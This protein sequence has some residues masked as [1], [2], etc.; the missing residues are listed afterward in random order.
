VTDRNPY[1]AP[2]AA[3]PISVLPPRR[4]KVG[5][6]LLVALQ[7][8]LAALDAPHTFALFRDGDI[9]LVTVAPA[10][11]ASLALMVG[12]VLFSS[13][14]GAALYAFGASALLGVLVLLQW[15]PALAA[16]GLAIALVACFMSVRFARASAK[17]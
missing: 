5:V 7:L 10:V 2:A 16:T 9:N 13:R 8:L 17:A 1:S 11:L 14:P 12:G 6:L 4:W 3:A 15:R